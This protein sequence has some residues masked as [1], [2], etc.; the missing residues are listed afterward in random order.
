MGSP[1][2]FKVLYLGRVCVTC[3]LGA[4]TAQHMLAC[5][6]DGCKIFRLAVSADTQLFAKLIIRDFCGAVSVSNFYQCFNHRWQVLVCAR[7]VRRML[8]FAARSLHSM[9]AARRQCLGLLPA[10][11]Q[12]REC[13]CGF[14]HDILSSMIVHNPRIPQGF[15][16]FVWYSRLSAAPRRFQFDACGYAFGVDWRGH[17]MRPMPTDWTHE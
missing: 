16:C 9:E 8:P 14:L 15:C 4:C 5:T 1:L 10:V 3:T 13:A 2:S 6:G 12:C 17:G 11:Q 7:D